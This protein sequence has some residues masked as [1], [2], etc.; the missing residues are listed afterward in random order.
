MQP[1]LLLEADLL[2]N[3]K[4]PG[5]PT[6]YD[7]EEDDEYYYIIEEYVQGQSMEAYVLRQN[8]ISIDMAVHMALQ[9]CDVMK[10]LHNQK[11]YPI[12]YQDLKPEHIIL[13]G[14]RIVLID[15]GI[16]IYIWLKR[17]K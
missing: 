12:I 3:L 17:G 15:F 11:P 8:C 14:K 4:H 9:I 6:I 10:Y 2:K 1:Q 16:R 13:C 5:I 7:V